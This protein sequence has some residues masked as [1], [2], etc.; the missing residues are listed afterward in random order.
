VGSGWE[1]STLGEA[2]A[3]LRSVAE[4]AQR[5]SNC[6]DRRDECGYFSGRMG[7]SFAELH[8]A[9][10]DDL[11]AWAE[12]QVRPSL[13]PRL[14][15]DDLAQEV[16]S[17][18]FADFERFDAARG[19]FRAWLFGIAYNVLKKQLRAFDRRRR[20]EEASLADRRI[21]GGTSVVTRLS[22]TERVTRLIA[23]VETLSEEERQLVLFRGIE[24]LS[25]ADVGARMR[26]PPGTAETRWRRVRA[27]LAD[28]LPE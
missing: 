18:A 26:I 23:I 27:K 3:L 20:H 11:C 24:G 25:H 6:R 21:D 7:P 14:D 13:R 19:P 5:R 1:A 2:T 22:R 4:V 9:L 8:R 16:W 17:R 28:L 15:P 10:N 12:V